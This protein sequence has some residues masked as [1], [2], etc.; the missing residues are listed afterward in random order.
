[1]AARIIPLSRTTPV[2]S[3]RVRLALQAPTETANPLGGAVIRY[4]AIATLWA[5]IEAVGGEEQVV[6][7]RP[8]GQVDTRITLRWRAGLTTRMRF[9]ANGRLFAIDAVFDPDGRRRNLTCLCRE[10]TP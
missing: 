10:I 3:R 4:S 6:A 8:E 2:A 9:F 5:R 7:A 1:M